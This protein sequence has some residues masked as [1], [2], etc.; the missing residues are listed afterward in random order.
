M[1]KRSFLIVEVWRR[2]LFGS[3]LG[4]LSALA[5]AFLFLSDS[6]N[7]PIPEVVGAAVWLIAFFSIAISAGRSRRV[8]AIILQERRAERSARS[9][10]PWDAK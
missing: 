8:A 3:F 6:S 4:I 2:D 9:A 5:L 10:A 7:W 1:A